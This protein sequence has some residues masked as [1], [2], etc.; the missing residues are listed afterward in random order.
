MIVFARSQNLLACEPRWGSE[1]LANDCSLSDPWLRYATGNSAPVLV[2]EIF[3]DSRQERAVVDRLRGMPSPTRLSLPPRRLKVDPEPASWSL[4]HSVEALGHGS[5]LR[6][7]EPRREMWRYV[8]MNAD[9]D[10]ARGVF[11]SSELSPLD[12]R[13]FELE[14]QG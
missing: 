9:W 2:T 1:Y 4:G 14:L 11:Q 5:S 6:P 7:S 3:C 12:L 8:C 10:A 13:V